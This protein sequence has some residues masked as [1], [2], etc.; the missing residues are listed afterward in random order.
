MTVDYWCAD[1]GVYKPAADFFLEAPDKPQRRCR[2]C[3]AERRN[4]RKIAQ[5]GVD[6]GFVKEAQ[7][8]YLRPR[9]F[10]PPPEE[11]AIAEPTAGGDVVCCNLDAGRLH[12]H[13]EG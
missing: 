7:D 11:N 6:P 8:F 4:E 2:K 9:I 5:R 1:C 12:P 3:T 10:P 13:G